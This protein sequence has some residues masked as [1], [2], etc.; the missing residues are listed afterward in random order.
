MDK[1]MVGIGMLDMILSH[2]WTGC[3]LVPIFFRL[4]LIVK[5]L[6]IFRES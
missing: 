1:W 5:L 2:V 4:V 3:F 6:D